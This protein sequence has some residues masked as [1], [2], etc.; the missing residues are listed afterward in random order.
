MEE[1]NQIN[2]KVKK[3]EQ[4]PAMLEKYFEVKKQYPDYLVF[5]RL[6][7]FYELF[8]DDA[9]LVSKLLN[10]VLTNKSNKKDAKAREEDSI[11]MCG[12]PFHA[13]E[14]YL[15]KLVKLGYKV[16]ICEQMETP[17]QARE[18]GY[19]AI[20]RREVTRLVTAGTLTEDTLLDGKKNNYLAC[21][22]VDKV[23]AC[24]SYVD[25]STGDFK[26]Q[27]VPLSKLYSALVKLDPAELLLD[28]KAKKNSDLCEILYEFEKKITFLPS[29]RFSYVNAKKRLEDFWKV[30]T[31]EAFG[32]FNEEEL[33][34]AGVL[35]DYIN[36]TQKG[37][38]P[39][40]K[41]L[42]KVLPTVYMDID[43]ATRRN[44]E[45]FTSLS[46]GRR[47]K[48]LL[49]VIDKTVTN[50]GGRLLS[51]YLSSPLTDVKRIKDRLDAVDFFVSQR[52]ILSKLREK[53]VG[54]PDMERAISRL[55]VKRGG[56]RD[57]AALRDALCLVPKLRNI[58][59]HE[60]LPE[61]LKNQRDQLHTLD[62]MALELQRTLKVSASDMPV[63]ARDG[64]FIAEGYS[65]KLDM[66]QNKKGEH[67][68]FI[69]ELQAQYAE[70]TQI[71]SLKIASNSLLGYFVEVPSRFYENLK[72]CPEIEFRHVRS[73]INSTRFTTND[74]D[75]F[76]QMLQDTE[77]QALDEELAIFER[78]VT[79]SMSHVE[80]LLQISQAVAGIDVASALAVTALENNYCRPVIDDSFVFEIQGGRHPVVEASLKE[81]KEG[82]FVENDCCMNEEKG[83]LWLLT[84]PNMAGKSTFLRQNALIAILAQIGSFVPASSARIG[85]IDKLFS[86]VGASDDL[87]R[88]RSTF[89]VEMIETSLI[90][91]QATDRSFVILDEIGRGTATFDGL[92]IAWAVA[93]YLHN[94]NKCRALFATHYHELTDLSM[95]L[96]HLSLHAMRTKQ[97]H[98]DVVFLYEVADGAVDRSYGIH[99][100]KLAGLPGVVIRR[101]EQVL[102]KLESQSGKSKKSEAFIEELPLFDK[103]VEKLYAAEPSE[104]E[105]ELLR[106][107]PD[108]FSPKEALEEL[109]RL[110]EMAQKKQSSAQNLHSSK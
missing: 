12:V 103:M 80:E 43:A 52:D 22:M 75:S 23:Q 102:A 8:F 49:N 17:E 108:E 76:N 16:A 106:I 66:L 89:M 31:L 60:L 9:K 65:A 74:L 73:M 54:F 30:A 18:R 27:T 97:W 36:L 85:V 109:Y 14:S 63:L 70:K 84:G 34:T 10:I 100:G 107:N 1:I 37:T 79:L 61:R 39:Y 62:E 64:G 95:T 35:M 86:R 50:V 99:V 32:S 56:P 77:Q 88:G 71:S 72:N 20:I 53:L 4:K 33:T 41:H 3:T 82:S 2:A 48:S 13:Y 59:D 101:A 91:N 47:G 83:R 40:L 104:A 21:M 57:L 29:S 7:D 67:E 55:S 98:S 25:I 44:L 90:L 15:E 24:M 28:E 68:A 96:P 94:V 5:Y 93:E 81:S 110:R 69:N 105:K 26:T 46:G 92:S 6:G 38:Y 42:Q 11:P 51:S 45:L 58:L 19:K 78:L 87:A